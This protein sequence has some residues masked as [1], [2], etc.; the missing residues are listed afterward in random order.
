VGIVN[1]R[2]FS[3]P[4]PQRQSSG[5]MVCTEPLPKLWVPIK[6]A[7]G[8][9]QR[10]GDPFPPAEDGPVDQHDNRRTATR[11]PVAGAR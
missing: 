4:A 10:T 11:S 5:I 1:A 8:G 9:L 2:W 7:R 6:V 3:P